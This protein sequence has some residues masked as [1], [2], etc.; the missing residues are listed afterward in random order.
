MANGSDSG[1]PTGTQLVESQS[2]L[3]LIEDYLLSLADS[4]QQTQRRLN[5]N[6]ILSLDGR[7]SI[8]YQ[9]PKVEFELKMSMEMDFE[10]N[11]LNQRRPVLKAA[12]VSVITTSKKQSTEAAST[13]KGVFVAVP[14]E[15]GQ[16]PPIVRTALR[17]I[18]RTAFEVK[19]LVQSAIGEFK[20]GVKV[21]FN[22]DRQ[23]STNWSGE[24]GIT[25]LWK[26]KE[27]TDG[28]VEEETTEES[29]EEAEDT[30]IKIIEANF[31]QGI[32]NTDEN[33]L[34]INVLNLSETVVPGTSI[35]AVIDVLGKT[36]TIVFQ[37]S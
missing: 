6:R 29:P 37:I 34:A 13:I 1:L 18:S 27:P 4:I 8:V 2:N 35:V 32:V 11:A 22:I 21:E 33:G 26:E 19:V 12:P 30:S 16:P 36:E 3:P 10:T 20:Q 25:L 28:E 31:V 17:E 15:G 24:D 14:G 5:Q 7:S 9:L 23:Q